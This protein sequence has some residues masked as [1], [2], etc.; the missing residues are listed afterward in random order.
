MGTR[1]SLSASRATEPSFT[2]EGDMRIQI[3]L[4]DNASGNVNLDVIIQHRAPLN[5]QS[6]AMIVLKA[7]EIKAQQVI[8][9][10]KQERGR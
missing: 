10:L 2:M 9:E 3:Q 8:A 6:P 1:T 5:L 7:L 4:E